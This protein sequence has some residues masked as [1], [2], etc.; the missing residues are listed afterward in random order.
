M[1]DINAFEGAAPGKT[2][3]HRPR[4]RMRILLL[5]LLQL[6]L[7]LS[8]IPVGWSADPRE[9]EVRKAQQSFEHCWAA[10]DASGMDKLLASDFTY[11]GRSGRELDR[12]SFLG[13]IKEGNISARYTA[14]INAVIHF[15]GPVAVLASKNAT[16]VTLI[17]V[18][19]D[20]KGWRLV[21]G[22]GT[23]PPAPPK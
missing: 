21:R 14:E 16:L 9:S 7:A 6:P 20:G 23:L 4:W 1:T 22:Q 15:Y 12:A 10:R 18:N 17:W 13:A 11:V 3:S 2:I 19:A 8:L 5:R